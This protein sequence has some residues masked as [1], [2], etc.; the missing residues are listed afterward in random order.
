MK[1]FNWNYFVK[2]KLTPFAKDI[3]YHQYDDLIRRGVKIEPSYPKEDENGY[4]E[5]QLWEFMQL[6]G[7]H[8]GMTLPNIL[9]DGLI[10]FEDEDLK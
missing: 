3:Y 9:K 10:Y 2:V 8:I 5:F 7:P 1:K 6:Y 4:C